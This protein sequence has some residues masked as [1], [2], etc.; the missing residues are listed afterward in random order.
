[1]EVKFKPKFFSRDPYTQMPSPLNV[2]NFDQNIENFDQ[3]FER[4]NENDKN[5]YKIIDEAELDLYED[6]N[7][8]PIIEV[9]P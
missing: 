7:V 6:Y 8:D 5:L 1:V 2:E 3:S 9:L 4:S